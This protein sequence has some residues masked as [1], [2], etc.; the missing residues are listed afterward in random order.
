M[1]NTNDPINSKVVIITGAS[2][3]SQHAG[4]TA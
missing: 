1:S 3:Y 2:R 4:R